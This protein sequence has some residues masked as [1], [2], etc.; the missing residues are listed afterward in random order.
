[1]KYLRKT[2]LSRKNRRKTRR[3]SVR[4]Y[5]NR[6]RVRKQ[7][8]G[9]GWT[10]MLLGLGALAGVGASQ[11]G[12]RGVTRTPSPIYPSMVSY[13]SSSSQ[14]SSSI[15][16]SGMVSYPIS[17][18]SLQ[19]QPFN[20]ST[21]NPFYASIYNNNVMTSINKN[22]NILSK[23]KSKNAKNALQRLEQFKNLYSNYQQ[24][25]MSSNSRNNANLCA[26]PSI[27]C[28]T[29][30]RYIMPQFAKENGPKGMKIETFIQKVQD[31]GLGEIT[32]SEPTL[33][34][35]DSIAASQ[36]EVS[37]RNVYKMV[38]DILNR[39]WKNPF[40]KDLSIIISSDNKIVDGHHR[41]FTLDLIEK[42]IKYYEQKEINSIFSNSNLESI[43]NTINQTQDINIKELLDEL[44]INEIDLYSKL[45]T[46][47]V[48]VKQFNMP[49]EKIIELSY[50]VGVLH[51]D[52]YS[53]NPNNWSTFF[54]GL[55]P[56][57]QKMAGF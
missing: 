38:K 3:K 42:I 1:M 4:K 18:T 16:P 49:I 31:L 50:T 41:S 24:K 46:P 27:T 21:Y 33:V 36:S 51:G 52:M 9:I 19:S 30:P 26:S 12:V 15:S 5:K 10:Q 43:I 14:L 47:E 54:T 56:S 32:I 40:D 57:G 2:V 17:T 11:N 28:G 20:L 6:T 44:K 25:G 48:S 55:P 7:Y 13:P 39:N 45:K 35:L 22:I 23:Q 29:N 8:G 34:P 53:W 37:S